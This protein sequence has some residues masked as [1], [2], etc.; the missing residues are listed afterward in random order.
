MDRRKLLVTSG[1][2]FMNVVPQFI[3]A[4]GI[5]L[6]NTII[7]AIVSHFTDSSGSGSPDSTV[8]LFAF[9]FGLAFFGQSFKFALINGVS[10]K[11]YF[12]GIMLSN[13]ATSLAW[14]VI[15][16]IFA[17][18]N[19]F[20]AKSFNIYQFVYSFNVW[21]LFIWL[22]TIALFFS[23]F[24]LF[25]RIL[26]YRCS[27]RTMLIICASLFIGV[28]ILTL[29]GILS[30]GAMLSS[31]ASFFAFIFNLKAASPAP[32]ICGA[33]FILLAA[34]QSGAIFLLLKKAPIKE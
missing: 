3:M 2:F 18:L 23:M 30:R 32:Y 7:A 16:L 33:F 24:G 13:L 5:M 1:Y 17:T 25:I 26:F 10:R 15:G 11:T 21:H 8:F 14:S 9:I 34:V 12:C 31:I 19:H 28:T 20:F 6:L 4:S 29:A 22:F 27:K